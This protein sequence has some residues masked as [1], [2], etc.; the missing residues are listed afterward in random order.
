MR[1]TTI[2]QEESKR[3]GKFA[4]AM[5]AC[6]G[7]GALVIGAT[8]APAAAS[9]AP[10]TTSSGGFTID[11]YTVVRDDPGTETSLGSWSVPDDLQGRTCVATST[12]ENNSSIHP[13][14]NLR[15]VSASTITLVDVEGT[16]SPVG[17]TDQ[18][19]LGSQVEVILVMGPDGVY[20]AGIAVSFDCPPP[21]T[22]TT[23]TTTTSTTT[24]TT[25]APTTTSSTT[26]TTELVGNNPPTTST[27][28]ST[29]EPCEWNPDLEPDDPNC[30][31]TTSER[32]AAAPP[33]TAG[34][35]TTSTSVAA[36]LPRTG[37]TDTMFAVGALLLLAGTAMVLTT[38]RRSATA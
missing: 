20:S 1:P 8:G 27:T 34:S 28:T 25:V 16:G 26:T 7:A 2:V 11:L 3:P 5:L 23:T 14:N 17:S 35:S 37:G 38:R 4:G 19:I 10:S 9:A 24:T 6:L 12:P 30:T 15:V 29:T 31:T 33:T 13:G 36:Q 21:P 22:T 18:I 32:V